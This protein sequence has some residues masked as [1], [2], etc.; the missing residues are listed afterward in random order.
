MQRLYL[1]E[2]LG[3]QI[4]IELPVHQAHYLLHV[5]RMKAGASLCVFNEKDGEWRAE[6]ILFSKKKLGVKICEFLRVAEKGDNIAYCFAPLKQARLDY[7]VQKAVELGA[8]ELIA[9]RTHYN[10]IQH[11]KE[12]RI[13]S[14]IIEAS[15]Q[16]GIVFVPDYKGL[17]ALKNFLEQW[18][19]TRPLFF[20]DEKEGG[21]FSLELLKE[22]N[23]EAIG[24]LI[25]P[26]GG[27]SAEER[28]LLK[29]K[30]FVIP[31]SLGKR[32]LRA[33]TAGVVILS[34][35]QAVRTIKN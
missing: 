29:E 14:N 17:Y 12:D 11:L 35:V 22:H 21:E 4:V 27:F 31:I 18:P 33:D 7:I 20:C 24:V 13:R 6:V 34:L 19:A 10:Q 3:E 8:S 5:L 16:C 25:G 28:A 1:P 26:E 30:S 2:K 32:I 23:Q 15:E 9:V